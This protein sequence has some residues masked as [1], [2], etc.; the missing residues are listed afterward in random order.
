MLR[1]VR[2]NYLMMIQITGE[3]LVWINKYKYSLSKK[4]ANRC[5][6]YTPFGHLPWK[7]GS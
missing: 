4:E 1:S 5:Q 6:N 7:E 3:N 2:F